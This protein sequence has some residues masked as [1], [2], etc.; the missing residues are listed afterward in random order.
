[1]TPLTTARV[2]EDPEQL[3]EVAKCERGDLNPHGCLA[4]RILNATS[5]PTGAVAPASSLDFPFAGT[6]PDGSNGCVQ[7]TTGDD[8]LARWIGNPDAVVGAAGMPAAPPRR[9]A[10]ARARGL[11]GKVR[12]E[13]SAWGVAAVT[14]AYHSSSVVVTR[15]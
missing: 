12:G 15:K 2:L 10:L 7:G 8:A 5:C 4:H 9:Q 13:V 3:R 1:M 14:S 6:A 11:F